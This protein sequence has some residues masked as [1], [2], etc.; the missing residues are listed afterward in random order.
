MDGLEQRTW[1][2]TIIATAT[3]FVFIKNLKKTTHWRKDSLFTKWCQVGCVPCCISGK[4]V[5]EVSNYLLM[6]LEACSTGG[7]HVKKPV[8]REAIGPCGEATTGDGLKENGF[9]REWH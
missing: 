9:Q 1:M 5:K 3:W 2:F 7:I 6:G 8:A 4:S